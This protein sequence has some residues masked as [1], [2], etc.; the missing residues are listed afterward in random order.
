M[1]IAAENRNNGINNADCLRNRI[2]H[3][4]QDMPLAWNHLPAPSCDAKGIVY[5]LHY[6]LIMAKKQELFKALT[7]NAI[8]RDKRNKLALFKWIVSGMPSILGLAGFR[9]AYH[10]DS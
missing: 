10:T 8:F 1:E 2:C 3:S 7:E 4:N 6:T 5:T 9:R